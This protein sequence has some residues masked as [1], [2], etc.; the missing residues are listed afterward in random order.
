MVIWNNPIIYLRKP[1][2]LMGQTACGACNNYCTGGTY[3][4]NQMLNAL[5]ESPC[6][7]GRWLGCRSPL[8]PFVS[9]T[10]EYNRSF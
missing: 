4:Q 6:A 9:S 7:S 2:K 8:I 3:L 1:G 5:Y 10:E